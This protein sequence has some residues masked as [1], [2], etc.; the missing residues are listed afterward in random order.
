MGEKSRAVLNAA[1]QWLA[2]VDAQ[3]QYGATPSVA[4]ELAEMEAKLAAAV[5]SWRQAGGRQFSYD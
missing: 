5:R 3:E 1:D 2:A 4:E